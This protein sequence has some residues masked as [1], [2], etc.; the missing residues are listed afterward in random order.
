MN[1]KEILDKFI[2]ELK[3]GPSCS[4]FNITGEIA[5][6][7]MGKIHFATDKPIGRRVALKVLHEKLQSSDESC[8]QFIEEARIT[9]LL[10]HSNIVPVYTIDVDE[11]DKLYFTMKFI[12]GDSLLTIIEQIKNENKDYIKYYSQFMLLRIFRKVC[13]AVSFAHS[14]GIVHR[15]IKPENIVIDEDGKQI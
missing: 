2:T 12:D 13:D 4:R 7:G 8:I 11:Q 3:T 1:N 9:G 10:E 6:G 5:E 15:D 14:K